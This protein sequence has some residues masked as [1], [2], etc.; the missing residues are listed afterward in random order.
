[1][2]VGVEPTAS[3]IAGQ[4][5]FS[6][7]ISSDLVPLALDPRPSGSAISGSSWSS[8]AVVSC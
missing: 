5:K 6:E 7:A 8:P 4:V 3:R 1:L 2:F